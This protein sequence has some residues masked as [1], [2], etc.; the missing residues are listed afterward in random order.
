MWFVQAVWLYRAVQDGGHFRVCM[1]YV[2]VGFTSGTDTSEANAG[3]GRSV[4]LKIKNFISH[5]ISSGHKNTVEQ[6]WS[7]WLQFANQMP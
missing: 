5:K 2:S 6:M 4:I 1:A 7:S 3:P